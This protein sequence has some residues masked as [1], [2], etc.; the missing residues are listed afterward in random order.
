MIIYKYSYEEY[1]GV[2]TKPYEDK[3]TFLINNTNGTNLLEDNIYISFSELIRNL[4]EHYQNMGHTSSGFSINQEQRKIIIE[5][6]YFE[7]SSLE[8]KEDLIAENITLTIIRNKKSK[9]L[10]N[11]IIMD[12]SGVLSY[13][14]FQ[15]F[16]DF[17]EELLGK[18]LQENNSTRTLKK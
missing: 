9:Q 4:L 13:G 18:N 14:Y 3:I 16:K 8:L 15:V 10:N 1:I 5:S 11:L 12:R 7:T 2:Q 6:E 17:L